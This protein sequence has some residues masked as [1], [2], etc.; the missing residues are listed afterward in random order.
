ME[1]FQ[2][3]VNEHLSFKVTEVVDWLKVDFSKYN[4]KELQDCVKSVKIFSF[5]F[6]NIN[7]PNVNK[8]AVD[9][10]TAIELNI[11]S[12]PLAEQFP[13][14]WEPLR[15]AN[16]TIEKT[17]EL[18][19]SLAGWQDHFNKHLNLEPVF[20][21]IALAFLKNSYCSNS[22]VNI[23]SEISEISKDWRHIYFFELDGLL[24]DETDNIIYMIESKYVF[25]DNELQKAKET[26]RKLLEYF[27]SNLLNGKTAEIRA[28]NR[29]WKFFFDATDGVISGKKSEINIKAFLGFHSVQSSDV[30]EKAIKADFI[31]IGPKTGASN[32]EVYNKNSESMP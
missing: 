6:D 25:N 20:T 15:K 4:L 29:R 9:L 23:F 27:N 17:N 8:K 30:I 11:R 26:K 5:K 18:M 32:Y 24:Y 31:L 13:E 2:N 21:N 16:E 19:Y 3:L 28:F 22:I 7:D 14:L 1:D 12:R 10:M